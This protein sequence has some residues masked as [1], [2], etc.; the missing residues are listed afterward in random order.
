M[1]FQFGYIE[2]FEGVIGVDLNQRRFRIQLFVFDEI[3]AP[4][5]FEVWRAAHSMGEIRLS[6]G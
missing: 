2:R 1:S 4:Q 5:L 6:P 3:K